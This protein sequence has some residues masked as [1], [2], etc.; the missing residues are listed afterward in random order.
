MLV[1][2][3]AQMFDRSQGSGTE[4][5]TSAAARVLVVDDSLGARAVVSGALASSGF[6]TSVASSVAEALEILSA[7]GADAVVVDFSMPHEDGI[8]LVDQ[9]RDRFAD[10]PVVMLSGVATSEDQDRAQRAGVD[11]FFE[12]ADFREGALAEA[13]WKMLD[14]R[15]KVG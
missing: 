9:V 15:G 12:K 2:D 6:T 7:E 3:A 13:L 14:S 4:A 1:L 5:E 11:A 8:A 10:L